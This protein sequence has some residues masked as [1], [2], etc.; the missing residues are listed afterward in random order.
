MADDSQVN[1]AN[2]LNDMSKQLND[3]QKN[4]NNNL[5]TADRFYEAALNATG[6]QQEALESIAGLYDKIAKQEQQ[7]LE[8]TNQA[9][10][11]R[12]KT[13]DLLKEQQ[14]LQEAMR[15]A[16]EK[17]DEAEI[18]ANEKKI[19]QNKME[20]D[21]TRQSMNE[22]SRELGKM[23]AEFEAVNKQIS[24]MKNSGNLVSQV[25]SKMKGNLVAALVSAEALR[26]A[27]G[28]VL[29]VSKDVADISIMSGM[30][31]GM[32]ADDSLGQNLGTIKD[33]TVEVSKAQL[34]LKA[35]GFSAQE[36]R[37]AFKDFAQIAGN[38]TEMMGA[39]TKAAGGLSRMLGVDLSETTEF[40]ID[41]NLKFNRTGYQTAKMLQDIQHR[42]EE[43]NK[44][45]DRGI[46]RGRDITKT[47]F[48]I[49]RES[50]VLAQDQKAISD[51]L[52]R[53]MTRLQGQGATYQE[54]LESA[55]TFTNVLTKDA[56]EFLKILSGR[57]VVKQLRSG[58][59]AM[60][61]EIEKSSPEIAKRVRNVMEDSSLSDYAKE[62]M[63][64]EL[65]SQTKVGL[66]ASTQVL[67]KTMD[68]F[69]KGAIERIQATMGVTFTQASQIAKQLKSEV[70]IKE[71]TQAMDEI[72]NLPQTTKEGL[73]QAA[74]KW[75]NMQDR[76]AQTFGEK[77]SDAELL[78][79][80]SLNKEDREEELKNIL[81]Q[82][83]LLAAKKA[84]E[85]RKAAQNA[86][87]DQLRR[88]L[89]RAEKGG[90]TEVA[91]KLRKE[92]SAKENEIKSLEAV[93]DEAEKKVEKVDIKAYWDKLIGLLENPLAQFAIGVAGLG[94][95]VTKE[96]TAIAQ[97]TGIIGLLTKIYAKMSFGGGLG[98]SG[99]PGGTASKS[100]GT[101]AKARGL[102][103]KGAGAIPVIGGALNT[104]VGTLAAGGVAGAATLA[105]G[106]AAAG[107]GGYLAGKYVANPLLDATTGEKNKYGQDSNAVER[108]MGRLFLSKEQYQ[109]IYGT[110]ASADIANPVDVSS[111]TATK[112]TNLAA[113]PGSQ[114]KQASDMT[115]RAE[116]IP[117]SQGTDIQLVTTIPFSQ[118][119]RMNLE[120]MGKA[121]RG[122]GG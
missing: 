97:R 76:T 8:T 18:A 106:V 6:K 21:Q 25:W 108:L 26:R 50:K 2:Q 115:Q 7:M 27:I 51:I 90:Q 78:K 83:D 75:K 80:Q 89:E 113:V 70:G 77:L 96:I 114:S 41:Q 58:Q 31:T 53:N 111:V 79:L 101:I 55:R 23:K 49:S 1:N 94:I 82:K 112:T 93:A 9:N 117:G 74:E 44:G 42:T 37:A 116:L 15:K 92:I 91:D 110:G 118:A 17:G 66:D 81:M 35:F 39:M 95:L 99:G 4:I 71:L 62:R 38:N 16:Q 12:K 109:D 46:I 13:K 119:M 36:A 72:E 105:A 86:E 5:Q 59:G 100:L 52:I 57:E 34:Q 107:A 73:D 22:R 61:A 56:P 33:Y 67:A 102:L 40:M 10:E 104:G 84:Q 48:D 19:Q 20:I 3:M 88:R 98:G 30:Y 87:L 43:M 65:T 63:I 121:P 24:Q 14:K 103:A 69:N 47:L 68:V 60:M 122:P 45:F 54:S 28:A 11:H 120:A 64:N 32:G 29:Q 85:D